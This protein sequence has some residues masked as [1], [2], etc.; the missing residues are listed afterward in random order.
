MSQYFT[1]YVYNKMSH[2]FTNYVKLEYDLKHMGSNVELVQ[3]WKD[4]DGYR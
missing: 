4:S 3:I 2:Y 1:N